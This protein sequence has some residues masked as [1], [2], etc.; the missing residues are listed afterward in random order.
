MVPTTNTTPIKVAWEKVYPA[1]YYQ[2]T[3]TII[4]SKLWPYIIPGAEWAVDKTIKNFQ[5][6]NDGCL[7]EVLVQRAQQIDREYSQLGFAKE[8][9]P[10][11][12]NDLGETV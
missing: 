5:H 4:G 3:L 8:T 9:T 12:G 2:L 6:M 11:L 10:L 7:L 1:L